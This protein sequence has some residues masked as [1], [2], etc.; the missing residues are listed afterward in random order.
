MGTAKFFREMHAVMRDGTEADL[1]QRMQA[2]YDTVRDDWIARGEYAALVKAILG[3]WTSGNCVDYMLPLSAKLAEEGHEALHDQLWTRTIKRQVECFFRA[4][5][6]VRQ[7]KLS[8]EDVLAIDPT[9]F[10]E[11]D[12]NS[13]FDAPKAS[14]FMLHRL[15][16]SLASWRAE[17]V[18]AAR[19]TVLPDTIEA[20]LR[21][22]RRPK[23]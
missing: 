7:S 19:A 6:P 21:M 3:N 22:L 2:A 11:F 14:S 9:G 5:A 13:Y 15:L 16:D 20:S 10:D 17:R 12:I 4:Y 8:A 18:R 23:I 1:K